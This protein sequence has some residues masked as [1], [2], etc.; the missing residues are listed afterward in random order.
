MK[1]AAVVLMTFG[2][3]YATV[4][5]AS[6]RVSDLDYLKANRCKGLAVGLASGDTSALDAMIKAQG[7]S[8]S[9][10]VLVRADEEMSRAKHEA[11][12]PELKDRLNAELSGAC[13]AYMGG[14]KE[15][16]AGR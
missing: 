15:V 4:A 6:D 1:A 3:A 16:A 5:T 7:R 11:A 14:G 8:R 10:A 2:L 13:V 9:D 12:R